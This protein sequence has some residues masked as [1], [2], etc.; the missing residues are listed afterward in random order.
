MSQVIVLGAGMVGVSTALALQAHGYEVTLLDRKAAGEETSYGNAGIIQSEAAEPYAFP[1]DPGTLLTFLAGRSNQLRLS[2]LAVL[3][4]SRAL[5]TYFNNSTPAR[6]AAISQTY[7]QL[8]RR[9]TEDHEPLI[10]ASGQGN[11]IRRGGFFEM[12]RTERA[13]EEQIEFA[14]RMRAEFDVPSRCLD[15]AAFAAVEPSF[16]TRFAGAVHWTGSWTCLSPG[17]LTKGYADLFVKRGGLFLTGDAASLAQ[18][19]SGWTVQ[20]ADGPIAAERVVLCLGPWSAEVLKPLG[21]RVRMVWKRGYHQHFKG[22]AP[23]SN[24][25]VDPDNGIALSPTLHGLRMATGASLVDLNDPVDRA[26]LAYGERVLG[27]EIAL[28]TPI[29]DVP[30]YG[31]RPCLPD[32]LPLVGQA[33]RHP[34][35]WLNFGHGHQGFTLGPTTGALLAE[36]MSGVGSDMLEALSPAN[37]RAVMS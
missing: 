18:T 15:G 1:R 6:H 29:E 24:P 28:G 11:L 31:H 33:P 25:C 9:A 19:G 13:F 20:S 17:N 37:R 7:A 26:Q 36:G 34:G 14:Q 27:K 2:P 21:Y 10:T 23:L 32:M 5:L 8:T 12:Y 3:R 30:W 35:L 4:M 16:T 22:A